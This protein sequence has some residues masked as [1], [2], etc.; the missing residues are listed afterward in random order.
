MRK[1]NFVT[2]LVLSLIKDEVDNQK[3]VHKLKNAKL[4]IVKTLM[5]IVK[6][7]DIVFPKEKN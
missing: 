3:Y 5:S 4:K 7:L 2:D 6:K 1:Q